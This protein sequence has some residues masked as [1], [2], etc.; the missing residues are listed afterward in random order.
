M[1]GFNLLCLRQLSVWYSNGDSPHS[2]YIFD[3]KSFVKKT[4]F[5]PPFIYLFILGVFISM[6]IFISFLGYNTVSVLL[7]LFLKMFSY[8]LWELFVYAPSLCLDLLL[9]NFNQFL[10]FWHQK[11][12]QDN[13]VF[14]L[15]QLWCQPIL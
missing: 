12:F 10:T 7:I 11:L 13:P 15:P 9:F 3:C 5:F 1:V 2:F 8:W 6:W 4:S 14:S